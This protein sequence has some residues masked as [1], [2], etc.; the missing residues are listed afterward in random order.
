MTEEDIKMRFINSAVQ[1]G[2]AF[3]ICFNGGSQNTFPQRFYQRI[4]I[5]KTLRAIAHGHLVMATV[6]RKTYTAF[7]IVYRLREA[8]HG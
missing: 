6:K 1:K 7:Q 5:N 8:S 2:L 3:R 4:A